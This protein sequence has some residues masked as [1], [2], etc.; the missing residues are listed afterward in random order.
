M[1]KI[2]VPFLKVLPDNDLFE[3]GT[4]PSVT[5]PNTGE[6]FYNT[7]AFNGT[8]DKLML[9]Y[10][11]ESWHY[12]RVT[13]TKRFERSGNSVAKEEYTNYIRNYKRQG[14]YK[15]HKSSLGK[16]IN[17][18]GTAAGVD[19]DIFMPYTNLVPASWWHGIYLIRRLW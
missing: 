12:R 13:N 1:F 14:L 2:R 16:N 10:D 3:G 6:I 15:N 8:F 5:H 7:S 19:P 17:I 9:V 11:H 4:Y 18:Y